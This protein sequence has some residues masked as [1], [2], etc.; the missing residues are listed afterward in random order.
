MKQF[1]DRDFLLD[2][3]TARELFHSHAAN[4]PIIDYHC[5]LDPAM[6]ADDHRF[7][8]ITEL[9]LGG[10]HYKWRAMRSNG[11]PEKYITGKDSTEWEK[12]SHWAATMPYC[13]RNPLYH[14][15]HLELLTAFGID[16]RLNP[17]TAREIF[18]E[19]NSQLRENPDMT[20]R[21]LMRKY[22]V[23]VVCT[24]DDPVDTLD[25]HKRIRESGF[26]I[27]VL[28]TWRPDKAM[29]IECTSYWPY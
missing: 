22:K 13:F 8:S 6:I 4:L 23:E 12:F 2:S 14:W 16:R 18:D 26:E 25:H 9:W 19:C 3:P 29:A 11:V 7:S 1:M 17:S 28:P 27:K 20:A 10:D 21:G 15:T 5:H 24:T